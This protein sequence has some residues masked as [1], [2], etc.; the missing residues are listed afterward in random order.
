MQQKK[1]EKTKKPECD[2][3]CSIKEKQFEVVNSFI[4]LWFSRCFTEHFSRYKGLVLD[5]NSLILSTCY[6]LVNTAGCLRHDEGLVWY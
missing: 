3:L 4:F 6:V 2:Y 1:T 5:L